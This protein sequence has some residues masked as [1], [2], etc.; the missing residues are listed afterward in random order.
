MS[1]SANVSALKEHLEQL[2]PGKWLSGQ[3]RPQSLATGIFQIDQNL[4]KGLIRQRITEWRGASSSGKTSLLRACVANWCS[5]GHNVAYID[6]QNKLVASD[7]A[8][9]EQGYCAASAP[10]TAPK[11][12]KSPVD[13]GRFWVIRVGDSILQPLVQASWAA[14]Q[15]IRSNTFD[16][17]VLDLGTNPIRQSSKQ[18]DR[19]YGRLQRSLSHAKTALLVI[20][21]SDAVESGWSC[22]TRLSFN[23]ENRFDAMKA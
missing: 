5:E 9:V 10:D 23:W 18:G 14:D 7:W 3:T 12:V 22:D 11:A 6:V 2:F 21:D 1:I 16:V 20:Q 8:F 17:V 19:I 15:L 4:P 13:P